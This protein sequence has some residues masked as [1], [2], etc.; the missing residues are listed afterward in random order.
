MMR[1]LCM[2]FRHR[3]KPTRN[4]YFGNAPVRAVEYRCTR[5]RVAVWVKDAP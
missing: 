4:W 3:L 5:C 1:L 2:L